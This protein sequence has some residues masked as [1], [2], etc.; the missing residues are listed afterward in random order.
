T[1]IAQNTTQGKHYFVLLWVCRSGD[2]AVMADAWAQDIDDGDHCFIGFEG[3]SPSLTG[4]S[5][6]YQTA[7]GYDVIYSFYN[8]ALTYN[9]CVSDALDLMCYDWFTC[10]F[11]NSVL[12][13]GYQ[14]WWPHNPTF[15]DNPETHAW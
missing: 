12:N 13:G 6:R 9:Y 3:A 2:D 10:D 7:T 8:Y 14:T 4:Y 5:L 11:E 1:D 15:C